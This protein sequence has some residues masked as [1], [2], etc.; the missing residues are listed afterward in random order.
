MSMAICTGSSGM[1]AMM[2]A[3]LSA[4]ASRGKVGAGFPPHSEAS[5]P[6][7]HS[8]AIQPPKFRP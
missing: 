6:I 4:K 1:T 5:A 7:P 8:S 3:A 2:M